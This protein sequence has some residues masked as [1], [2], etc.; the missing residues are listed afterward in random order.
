MN[1]EIP[2][3]KGMNSI[4]Y[5]LLSTLVA[6]LGGFMFGFDTA[7]IS[8]TITA[9]QRVFS[10]SDF[11]LGFTVAVAL[12]GTIVGS[13]SSGNPSEKFGR[14]PVMSLLGAFFLISTLGCA[15][16]GNWYIFLVFRFIG[17][18]GIG[19]ASVICPMYI[20]ELAP[21][22]LRGRLVAVQQLNIVVGILIAFL[23]NYIIAGSIAQNDWRWMFGVGAIPAF[24]FMV[25]VWFIPDS[26]R[27]LVKQNRV[28]EAR[29]ILAKTG[30]KDVQQEIA[31][32]IASLET[33][34]K[35]T[36][37]K[38]FQAKYS[39]PLLTAIAIAVFN[40]LSGIN[41]IL[42]YAPHIFQMT[43]LSQNSALLQSIAIGLTNLIFTIIAM[44][45]ID[46]IGRKK[47]LLIGSVG[48]VIFLGLAAQAFFFEHFGGYGV[49]IYL[50]GFIAF[51]AVSQGAVIWVYI[52][53]IFPNRIRGK[54]Q[55][56]GTFSNWTMDAIISW[57][58]PIMASALGGGASFSIFAFMMVLQFIF[59]WWYVPETKGKS[60]EQIQKDLEIE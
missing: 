58:F 33:A 28:D 4:G 20:A 48:M 2:V 15:L 57:T 24:L 25:L 60:L 45:I 13:I 41:A 38:I 11:L 36:S 37:E 21:A 5:V 53:E 32:I 3:S 50:V 10:L 43:G 26:P 7:V 6:A 49:L 27:W 40:Q 34:A 52:S 12:I 9:L 39:I 17:G 14:R 59:V 31:D 51:F 56:V 23:S 8:G 22:R 46:K 30:A 19:G 29:A 1:K 44:T 42:Y 47:L 35:S 54:G 55:A 16:T 18:L